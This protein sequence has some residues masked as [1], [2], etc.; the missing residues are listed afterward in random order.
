MI[1]L[2]K[3]PEAWISL[4]T[5]TLM[6]IVLGIDNIIFLA[7][8]AG[9]LPPEEQARARQIGLAAALGTRILLLFTLSFLLGLT[10][11]VTGARAAAVGV[12]LSYAAFTGFAKQG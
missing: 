3:Q 1:E 7:I 10:A 9:K 5:L 4:A 8:E 6:E 11:L 12:A 2:L